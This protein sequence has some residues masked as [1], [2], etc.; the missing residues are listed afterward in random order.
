MFPSYSD[1]NRLEPERTTAKPCFSSIGPSAGTCFSSACSDGRE[2]RP[3]RA[4]VGVDGPG[5]GGRVGAD[6]RHRHGRAPNGTIGAGI[7]NAVPRRLAVVV[8]VDELDAAARGRDERDRGEQQD[9]FPRAARLI[10]LR[11]S[12]TG[13]S[14]PSP[15]TSAQP[16]RPGPASSGSGE[17]PKPRHSQAPVRRPSSAV[18]RRVGDRERAVAGREPRD[19]AESSVPAT[20]SSRAVAR[21]RRGRRGRSARGGRR[22]ARAGSAR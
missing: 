7:A 16:G 12:M 17:N 6:Q 22:A 18:Q 8:D 5:V 9:R 14:R 20:Q 13:S 11:P 3:S 2:R 10:V 4:S 15:S 21:A 1:W 19:R